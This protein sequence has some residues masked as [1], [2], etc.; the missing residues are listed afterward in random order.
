MKKTT[1]EKKT[2]KKKSQDG[3]IASPMRQISGFVKKRIKILEM[4][5][6]LIRWFWFRKFRIFDDN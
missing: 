6:C 3:N 2:L 5:I 4:N 1:W